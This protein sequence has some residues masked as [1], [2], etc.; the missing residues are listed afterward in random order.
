[1]VGI[2]E[3]ET[4][5]DG[6]T[7]GSEFR[8]LI[9]W[10]DL[11]EILGFVEK[12]DLPLADLDT[13]YST[14][15][16]WQQFKP[17]AWNWLRNDDL[18][19]RNDQLSP[20]IQI[21]VAILPKLKSEQQFN[22]LVLISTY[23]NPNVPWS[24]PRISQEALKIPKEIV[25]SHMTDYMDYIKS[26]LLKLT[27]SKVSSA[28]YARS[29][30]VS[31]LQP[32]LGHNGG[33][34]GEEKARNLWKQSGDV[35]SL[36]LV[37]QLLHVAEHWP[38]FVNYWPLVTMFILNVL[39]DSDPLF[40]AQGCVL[41]GV[42]A[43]KFPELLT[44][45]GLDQVFKQSVEVCL[46]YLPQMTPAKTSLTVLRNSYPVLFQLM[47][48][49]NAR[50]TD[51]I[52]VLEKNVLGL[53]SHVLNRDNDSDTVQV[54]ILLS[55]Q[56]HIIIKD[57]LDAQVLACF[58]RLNF[59]VSQILINPYIIESE[60]GPELVNEA[61][62]VHRIILE[63]F[64]HTDDREGRKLLFLYRYDLLGAWTVLLRRVMKYGVGSAHTKELILANFQ[65]LKEMA[66]SC[67][68]SDEYKTDLQAI[69]Q[70]CPEIE[71]ALC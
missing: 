37:F 71:K 69:F 47:E 26:K 44:K 62:R 64:L 9:K 29:K 34:G 66:D 46:T 21:S 16:E 30:I 5:Q 52:D 65:S 54:L 4:P 36:S 42:F 40:R 51:Y 50:F 31:A 32:T 6:F 45:S 53:I 39:D 33:Y 20:K 56:L 35:T 28:G 1:M 12:N 17:K 10:P 58:S 48:L 57:H 60:K 19:D 67:S 49:Q 43:S 23:S 2:V 61:L 18:L 38:D 68:L 14:L 22:L 59:V 55:R 13:L 41:L 7:Q 27:S 3:M 11:N 24:S 70:K 63:I 8:N 15:T 25:L